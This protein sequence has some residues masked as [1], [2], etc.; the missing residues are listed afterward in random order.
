MPNNRVAHSYDE[1]VRR[2]VPEPDSS[3]R[4]SDETE[5]AAY[6][7]TRILSA[8]EQLLY[9]RVSDALLEL[10]DLD[11]ADINLEIERTRVTVRGHV[12]DAK[13]MTLV[14]ER[15]ADV[16]DVTEVLNQL[17]VGPTE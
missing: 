6:E 15:I 10:H 12:R 16:D 14:E 3:W 2:T 1:I 8:D 9:A 17:I 4:P 5:Q 11:L 7:G 13:T